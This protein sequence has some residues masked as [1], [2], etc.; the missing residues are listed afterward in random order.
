MQ[1]R[2]LKDA[3]YYNLIVQ[4]DLCGGLYVKKIIRNDT[5]GIM[6][7]ISYFFIRT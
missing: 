6:A 2:I 3:S 1:G 7:V 5:G 4:I